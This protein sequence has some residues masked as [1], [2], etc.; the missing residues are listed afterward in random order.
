MS[1]GEGG[2]A[3]KKCMVCWL[4]LGFNGGRIKHMEEIQEWIQ[5]EEKRT[6]KRGAGGI[7]SVGQWEV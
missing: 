4:M 1:W 3:I 2:V 5:E 6:G 7:L